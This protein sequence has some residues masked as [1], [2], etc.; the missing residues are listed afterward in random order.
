MLNEKKKT[1]TYATT[2]TLKDRAAKKALKEGMTLSERIDLFLWA[3]VN[4]RPKKFKTIGQELTANG[5]RTGFPDRR[6]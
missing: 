1:F 3:Y 4:S 2:Q 6:P 5:D